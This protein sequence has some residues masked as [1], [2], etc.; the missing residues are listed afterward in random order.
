MSRI[1]LIRHGECAGNREGLFRGRSDFPLNQEGL[2]QAREVGAALGRVGLRAV[3]TSPLR[4]ASQTAEAIVAAAGLGEAQPLEAM[5]NISLGLWEGQPKQRIAELYPLQWRC[6]LETPE[7]LRLEGGESI[8]D[9]RRRAGLALT[10]LAERHVDETVAL[11]SHRAVI[12]CLLAEVLGLHLPW[13]WKLHLENCGYSVVE[14]TAGG[15][16][17]FHHNVV[18]HLSAF[19]SERR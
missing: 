18:G 13:V 6:W 2:R 12:K 17:L 11:V 1:Y 3:Y 5:N 14:P 10:A 9:V 15:W 7:T 16:T 4:R 19:L 8:E